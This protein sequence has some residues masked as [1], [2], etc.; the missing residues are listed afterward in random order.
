MCATLGIHIVVV[1]ICLVSA[2]GQEPT[3]ASGSASKQKCLA[4]PGKTAVAAVS[5][6]SPDEKAQRVRRVAALRQT[7]Q[8]LISFRGVQTTVIVLTNQQVPEIEDLHVEQVVKANPR[9]AP[10]QRPNLCMPWEALTALR[11]MST[12]GVTSSCD[13]VNE[14]VCGELQYDY[15]I[16]LEDDILIPAD[17]F[18]FWAKHVEDLYLHDYLLLPHRRESTTAGALT[19]CFDDGCVLRSRAILDKDG[20]PGFYGADLR[21]RVF[22]QPDNPYTACFLMTRSQFRD[23][24]DGVEWNA[25]K[26]D[27]QRP[28]YS[29][30]GKKQVWGT[31][32]Q[33]AG[34]L[35]WD[36]RF[37]P[38]KALTHL[39]IPVV[40]LLP[41]TSVSNRTDNQ[42]HHVVQPVEYERKVD[43][44]WKNA[45]TCRPLLRDARQRRRRRGRTKAAKPSN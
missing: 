13:L 10:K 1:L 42:Y 36:P 16:Y 2:A 18:E 23:Y 14:A 20:P 5:H 45:G 41:L 35:L 34:G 22:L 40:H 26:K 37:G 27:W 44:C 39:R 21:D 19:D 17:S 11:F 9:C 25:R 15:Y 31:R 30:G 33:A 3:C 12:K 29:L 24:V 7:L 8:A 6:W 43:H 32:E 28:S 38:E 4:K